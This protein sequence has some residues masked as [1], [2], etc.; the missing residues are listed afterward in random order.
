M[1]ASMHGDAAT[2]LSTDA[3]EPA[4]NR[5][6]AA[7]KE[8]WAATPQAVRGEVLRMEKELKAGLEKYQVAAARD[9][10]LADFHNRADRRGTSLKEVLSG[11]VRLEDMLRADPD[12]GLEVLFGNIGISPCE[13]A[14]KLLGQ[15]MDSVT[16]AVTKFAATRPRF[17]EL[18]EDI[19]FFL[20]TGRAGDLAEAYS[21]AER[22]NEN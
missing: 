17:D 7:A 19:V 14:V 10:D 6:T 1:S 15:E 2:L 20:D 8:D 21:L 9:A 3:I 16:E 11:Y 12:K 5:F 22:F 18:S 4:P 13:W